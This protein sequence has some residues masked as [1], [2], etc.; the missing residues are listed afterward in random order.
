MLQAPVL[1]AQISDRRLIGRGAFRFGLHLL[2]ESG[3]VRLQLTDFLRG[4]VEAALCASARHGAQLP[5]LT[6]QLILHPQHELRV[7][8]QRDILFLAHIVEFGGQQMD[9]H[10]HQQAARPGGALLGNHPHPMLGV[11]VV[12]RPL[13]L[14]LVE[15]F[16]I[17][18]QHQRVS[19]V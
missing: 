7:R 19:C 2:S 14:N 6:A 12:R 17:F 3:V 15:L 10:I 16:V 4:L 1:L 18:V 5:Q 13:E 8:P 11:E 9:D